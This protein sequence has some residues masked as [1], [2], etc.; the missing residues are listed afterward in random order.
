MC[1]T[2]WIYGQTAPIDTSQNCILGPGEESLRKH[3]CCFLL[4]TVPGT[5]LHCLPPARLHGC[6]VNRL[7]NQRDAAE[8]D[9]QKPC[10]PLAP[11]TISYYTAAACRYSP[12]VHRPVNPG[13]QACYSAHCSKQ[14]AILRIT[15][16][17]V[18]QVPV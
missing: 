11:G 4:Q 5:Q 1:S 13:T 17:K 14:P 2:P 15:Y 10:T 8:T 6:W 18:Y 16:D 3:V 12:V 9:Q 7:L